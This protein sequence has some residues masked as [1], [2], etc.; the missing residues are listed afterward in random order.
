MGRLRSLFH[1]GMQIIQQDDI[2]SGCSL[3]S[4]VVG[5]ESCRATLQGSRCLDSVSRSQIVVSPQLCRPVGNIKGQVDPIQIRIGGQQSIENVDAF[6]I[7]KSIRLYQ[8]FQHCDRRGNGVGLWGL[9]PNEDLVN[10]FKVSRIPFHLK[11]ENTGIQPDRLVVFK[12]V[13][14]LARDRLQ[15]DLSFSRYPGGY[16]CWAIPEIAFEYFS[17][18]ERRST[19]PRLTTTNSLSPAL[20]PR[21]FLASRGTTIWFLADSFTSCMG[22]VLLYILSKSKAAFKGI[23]SI[24]FAENVKWLADLKFTFRIELFEL[25]VR[26]SDLMDQTF[27]LSRVSFAL[28]TVLW[29]A[30]AGPPSPG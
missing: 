9:E 29:S 3:E 1:F 26:P 10:E 22:N 14:Q 30:S 8:Q 6:H 28:G 25:E 5:N 13:S 4:C 20:T 2:Q 24:S 21:A 19:V 16:R 23:S 15:A 12:K 27:L 7:R 18:F 17:G 11:D